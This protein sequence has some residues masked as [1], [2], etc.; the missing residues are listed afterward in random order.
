MAVFTGTSLDGISEVLSNLN[1]ELAKIE[2]ASLDGLVL[3]ALEVQADA[4]KLTP[5][6]TGNLQNSAYVLSSKKTV[7]GSQAEATAE[8][9]SRLA[10]EKAEVENELA[11]NVG[12]TAMYAPFVHENPR[13]GK[14]GGKSP[15]GIEYKPEKGS[16]RI[17]YSTV[18]QWK[19]LETALKNTKKIIAIVA[20]KAKLR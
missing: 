16:K 6:V 5:V 20:A 10:R 2:G 13:A 15:K 3:A 1:K 17:V 8:A 9:A 7:L 18:G 12:F 11:V 14:T 19:F 4:Q